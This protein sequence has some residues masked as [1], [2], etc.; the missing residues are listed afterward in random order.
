MTKYQRKDNK[1]EKNIYKRKIY[2]NL[3]KQRLKNI[4][5]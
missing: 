5:K 2:E 1:I 4:Q 3:R